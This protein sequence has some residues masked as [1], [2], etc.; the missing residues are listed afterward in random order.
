MSELILGLIVLALLGFLA[1][2]E[3]SNR[4]ERAKF[5]NALIAKTPEEFRDLELTE[6]VEPIKPNTQPPEFV[7]EQDIPEEQFN[8]MIKKEIA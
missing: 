8:E 5:I 6:K 4:R 1:W 2:Q 7:P 3:Y